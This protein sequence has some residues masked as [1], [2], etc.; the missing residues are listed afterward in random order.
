[1]SKSIMIVG[2]LI[3]DETW[4]VEVTRL[5]PEAPVPTAELL[6]RHPQRTPGGAGFAAAWAASQGVDVHF[7]TTATK[8]NHQELLER[9][10]KVYTPWNNCSLNVT[11]TRFIEQS[12]GYH[13]LRLDNDRLVHPP[14]TT[15]KNIIQCM[16]EAI[17][18][19]RIDVCLL[20]DYA[21][22]FFHD[23]VLW[24]DIITWLQANEI[25]TILD[26]RAKDIRIWSGWEQRPIS[27]A[28]VKLNDKEYNQTIEVLDWKIVK[29]DGE[30]AIRNEVFSK[31]II[32]HGKKGAHSYEAIW[33]DVPN[34]E[35]GPD[36]LVEN[37]TPTI[38][39]NI[40]PDPTGC[41]D[42]F[43]VSFISAI[44][45][46]ESTKNALKYA[47]EIATKYAFI[48]FKDKFNG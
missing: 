41:G 26:T 33:P 25:P 47:V 17:K 44:G 34:E 31:L 10:I 22:G 30:W 9:G 7:V 1:M 24:T 28:W 21:K 19:C 11:K 5:N 29:N 16:E 48:Q 45:N 35:E 3:I 2:D 23:K 42:I 13:L 46:G 18:C 12:S 14:P 15:P 40:A 27:H 20:S 32:T 43:D 37:Y 4:Q 36:I 6:G 39:T 38:I 8:K